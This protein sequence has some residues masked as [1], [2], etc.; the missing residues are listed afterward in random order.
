MTPVCAVGAGWALF[1]AGVR[2]QCGRVIVRLKVESFGCVK[3]VALPLTP[4]HALCGPNDSGKTTMLRSAWLV[5]KLAQIA[6]GK[7]APVDLAPL[8]PHDVNVPFRMQAELASRLMFEV[9]S[10]KGA[11]VCNVHTG[12]R[13][14]KQTVLRLAKG[15]ARPSGNGPSVKELWLVLHQMADA[16]Y[17][18]LHADAMRTPS[19]L[20]PS[21]QP[22]RTQEDGRGL[23]SVYD[24][25]LARG[26]GAYA[27][28]IARV[29]SVH[30]LVKA[31]RVPART[32]ST[33]AFLVEMHDGALLQAEQLGDGLLHMLAFAALPYS[34]RPALL[35][36]EE[37]ERSL[38]PGALKAVME[39]LRALA[40]DSARPVQILVAT[41]SPLVLN[42]LRPH[43][44][45]LTSRDVRFGTRI[46]PLTATPEWESRGQSSLPGSLYLSIQ[47]PPQLS[48]AQTI[49]TPPVV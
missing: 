39:I 33:K 48:G 17:L 35:L 26:D 23:A 4:L 14:K 30:P 47:Q 11:F 5:G 18:R 38:H 3:K 27:E 7:A 10:E 32:A 21:G 28:L 20:I 40:E 25:I 8:L 42:E 13:T 15:R 43:E 9:V 31:I 34:D 19:A 45:T 36:V 6:L 24:A 29:R 41:H 12:E 2:V 46:T 37:P 49:V 44:V 22:V 16:M 1:P